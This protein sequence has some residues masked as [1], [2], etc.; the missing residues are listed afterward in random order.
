MKYNFEHFVDRRGTDCYKWDKRKERFGREDIL[1]LWV[2]DSDWYTAPEIIEAI[3]KRVDHGIFGYTKPG[4]EHDEIVAGWVKRRYGW[5]IEPEWVTYTSGIVPALHVAVRILTGP[6]EGVLLQSPVYQPFFKAITQNGR[7]LEN[8]QLVFDGRKYRMDFADLEEKLSS[9]KTR[10]MILCSP[11]NPVGRVWS[12]EELKKLGE[13]C[14]EHGVTVIS[15]EIHADLIF[16]GHEFTPFASLSKEFALN[17][18]TM[19]SPS[20]TFNVAGLYAS[21]IIIPDPQI[22]SSFLEAAQGLIDSV[23]LFGLTALKAAYRDGDSWLDAQLQ[24]LQDNMEFALAY[25]R[26]KIPGIKVH[27]PEGT[28]LLWLNCREISSDPDELDHFMVHEAGVGLVNG[29]WFGSGGEGFMRLNIACPKK[30][31]KEGL[32]RIE[33]AVKKRGM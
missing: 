10:V 13:I 22:R 15:D 11:H 21:A 8:S 32:E 16:K 3:K 1:P 30:T 17:S 33:K 25:I 18:I 2:A 12:A 7:T 29:A 24:Y 14:L 28:Y 26:E 4:R 27:E 6:A 31:L 19:I 5:E 23:S 20:K 9:E